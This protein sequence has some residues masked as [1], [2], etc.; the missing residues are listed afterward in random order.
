[1]MPGMKV[2][3][4]GLI[5]LYQRFISPYKGFSCAY[6]AYTGRA[7]CSGLGYRAI[8]RHGAWRGYLILRRRLGRCSD[9]Q[10]QLLGRHARMRAQAGFCD[11]PVDC[12]PGDCALPG[13]CEL[14]CNC[15]VLGAAADIG[16]DCCGDWIA[17]RRER[18]PDRRRREPEVEIRSEP[19]AR[20]LPVPAWLI[21]IFFFGG[22]VWGLAELFLVRPALPG[23]ADL[24]L[25]CAMLLEVIASVQLIR[26]R[27]S[28]LA[29]YGAA[30][31]LSLAGVAVIQ[32]GVLL[33]PASVRVWGTFAWIPGAPAL[34][35]LSRL[36]RKG[37]IS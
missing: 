22:S 5:R 2:V 11:A 10:R 6:R 16:G 32:H 7:G 35:Y 34:L 13:T 31:V 4:L 37:R 28:C 12:I 27:A 29:W 20:G 3:L 18:T 24:L 1:M 36:R 19:P 26:R 23:T 14:P 21:A 17:D 25:A 30:C 8:R 33:L 9:A 15:D